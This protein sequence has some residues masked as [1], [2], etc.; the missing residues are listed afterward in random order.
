VTSDRCLAGRVAFI[1]G[2]AR[3][4]GA[5][6]AELM[7]REGASVC[8]CDAD[9]VGAQRVADT[10]TS[11]GASA[12]WVACDVADATGLDAAVSDAERR[13]GPIDTLFCNAGVALVGDAAATT[14]GDWDRTLAVNLAGVWNG[15]RS[16]IRRVVERAGSASIVN[17]ASVNA[18]FAEP[19]FAAYCASKGGVLAL[20]RAL[21]L[22]Y[23]GRG[24]RVNCVCPGYMDTAMVAPFLVD[25]DARA[26]ASDRHALGRIAQPEEVAEVVVFLASDDASFITGAAIVVDGGMSIGNRIV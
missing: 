3:G 22:D 7:T 23:A 2:A 4:L 16:V 8:V 25:G 13:I 17:T 1:T 21:A 18:F 9:P 19:D 26:A 24:I 14:R 10:L 20:T 11:R 5:A 12:T 6:T 15:C